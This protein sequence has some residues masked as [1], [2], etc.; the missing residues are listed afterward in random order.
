MALSKEE[1]IFKQIT[2]NI[3]QPFTDLRWQIIVFIF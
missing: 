1:I 3:D 2:E